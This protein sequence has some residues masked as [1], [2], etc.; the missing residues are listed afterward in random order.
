[1]SSAWQ[2]KDIHS[3][4]LQ[5]LP[6]W[7]LC[8]GAHAPLTPQLSRHL[9]PC[10]SCPSHCPAVELY[11]SCFL[12]YTPKYSSRPG[13]QPSR[14][15]GLPAPWPAHSNSS[16][17]VQ[18]NFSTAQICYNS[19]L[20]SH[21]GSC[22]SSQEVHTLARPVTPNVIGARP[23]LQP[24]SLQAPSHLSPRAPH[25]SPSELPA[26]LPA[27]HSGLDVTSGS[28]LVGH[29]SPHSL[30]YLGPWS[31]NLGA[32]SLNQ[33]KCSMRAGTSFTIAS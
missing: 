2:A 24:T 18:I 6:G 1:M 3:V 14:L 32:R 7:Q 29:P 8:T 25:S 4:S 22:Y 9:L 12:L 31:L 20:K 5:P 27:S 28:T 19:T 13:H 11:F 30:G 10:G 26:R 15:I 21:V 23:P 17:I 16:F 33:N